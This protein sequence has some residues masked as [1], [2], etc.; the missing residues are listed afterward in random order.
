MRA[1]NQNQH[2]STQTGIRQRSLRK[3]CRLGRATELVFVTATGIAL[4]LSGGANAADLYW[5]AGPDAGANETTGGTGFWN[6]TEGEWNDTAASAQPSSVG[7]DGQVFTNGDSVFFG[8]A[9][10]GAG[11]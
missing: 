1:H 3:H 5:D 9:A 7:A 11:Y 8:P 10:M 2:A 4:V 6:T